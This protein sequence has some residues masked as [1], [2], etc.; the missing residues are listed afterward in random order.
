MDQPPQAFFRFQANAF[1]WAVHIL[2]VGGFL[3]EASVLY[4][5]VEYWSEFK[6]S[7][8]LKHVTART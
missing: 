5:L 2:V 3:S 6:Q 4:S 7:L 8:T 1:P